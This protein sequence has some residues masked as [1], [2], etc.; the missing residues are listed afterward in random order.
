MK[1]IC[2]A[3][4]GT[5]GSGKTFIFNQIANILDYDLFDTGQL[6]RAFTY[7]LHL[8]KT[9][10]DDQESIIAGLTN[11]SFNIKDKRVLIN[12]DLDVTDSL[13]GSMVTDNINQVTVIAQVRDYMTK[14][15][16]EIGYREGMIELGRD[17]TSVVLPDADLKIYL[18]SP[19]EI[20]AQRRYEQNMNEGIDESYQD[21]L[22]K[23]EARDTNDKTRLVGPLVQTKDSW[24]LD[25]SQYERVEDL[26]NVIVQR[27]RELEK[28]KK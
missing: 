16:R 28:E 4:D 10:F 17:I 13:N 20:R 6:Y 1:K 11:F 2:I 19:I 21:V 7:Y 3:V 25:S 24:Y 5:A 26:V 15:E 22:K 23:I 18:D 8:I 14:I 27:V 9:N 12:N